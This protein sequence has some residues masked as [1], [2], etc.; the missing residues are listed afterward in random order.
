MIKEKIFTLKN[1]LMRATIA[2]AAKTITKP[3]KAAVI[4][5]LASSVLALS[6]PEAIH[7]TPPIT[8]IKK[9]ITAAT[10]TA[11]LIKAEI[12]FGKVSLIKFSKPLPGAGVKLIVPA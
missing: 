6:P 1:V 7:L 10:T 11:S 12:M 8:R 2:Q 5:L 9:K 4:W 3:T